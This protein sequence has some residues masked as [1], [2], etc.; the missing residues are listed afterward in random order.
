M[1]GQR[2]L[3]SLITEIIGDRPAVFPVYMLY[4]T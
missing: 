2:P 4:F 1:P 3:A